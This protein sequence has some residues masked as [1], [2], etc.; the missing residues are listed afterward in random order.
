MK[1]I[2]FGGALFHILIAAVWFSIYAI[3]D[4]EFNKWS[5]TTVLDE[6]FENGKRMYLGY[7]FTWEGIGRPTILQLDFIKK[8]GTPLAGAEAS[9]IQPYFEVSQDG[10]TIGAVDEETVIDDGKLDHPPP[11]DS[12]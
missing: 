4:G 6:H 3:N 7:N 1:K 8:D 9:R 11:D 10:N 5:H 2:L 12:I